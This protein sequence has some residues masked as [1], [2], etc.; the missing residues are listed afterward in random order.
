MQNYILIRIVAKLFRIC[1]LFEI[2][3]LVTQ[4]DAFVF[5]GCLQAGPRAPREAALHMNF[6]VSTPATALARWLAHGISLCAR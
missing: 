2:D 1:T 5:M 6:R 3:E 4:I